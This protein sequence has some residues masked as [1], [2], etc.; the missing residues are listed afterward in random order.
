MIPTRSDNGFHKP[1]A[2]T[3]K[4]VLKRYVITQKRNI[5]F[6]YNDVMVMLA[7][8]FTHLSVSWR[9]LLFP[10]VTSPALKA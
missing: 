5:V 6:S 9:I 2:I 4:T 1:R 8:F 10:G 3:R 7:A